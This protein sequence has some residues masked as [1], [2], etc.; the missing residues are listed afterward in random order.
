M[1]THMNQFDAKPIVNLERCGLR[2]HFII[3]G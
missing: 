1:L 3:A 2:L